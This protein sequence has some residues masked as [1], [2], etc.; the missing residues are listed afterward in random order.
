[1]NEKSKKGYISLNFTW[2]PTF[3]R[4]I[5]FLF[6]ILLFHSNCSEKT[7]PENKALQNTFD[8]D[9]EFLKKF[10]D[11]IVLK[12]ADSKMQLAISPALQGRVMTSSANGEQGFSYGWIN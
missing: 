2:M 5:F 11:I 12:S 3:N 8:A 6:F 10:T 1:M 7:N 4:T 9:V